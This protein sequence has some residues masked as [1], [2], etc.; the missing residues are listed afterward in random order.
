MTW[1][2]SLYRAATY[3]YVALQKYDAMVRLESSEH[4]RG[5]HALRGLSTGKC[6]SPAKIKSPKGALP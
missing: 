1:I 2:K 3:F 4:S 6:S 5:L